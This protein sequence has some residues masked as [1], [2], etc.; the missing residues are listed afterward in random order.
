MKKYFWD[1]GDK[2]TFN[3]AEDVQ[4][5]IWLKYAPDEEAWET[6]AKNV[7]SGTPNIPKEKILEGTSKRVKRFNEEYIEW[8]KKVGKFN[9]L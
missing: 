5:S 4:C 9:K 6:L 1:M 7:S 2:K 8:L 3:N